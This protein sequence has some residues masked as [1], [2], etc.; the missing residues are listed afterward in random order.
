M[1]KIHKPREQGFTIIELMVATTIFSIVLMVILASFLQI[2]RMFYKGISVSNT[3]ESARSVVEDITSDMKLSQTFIANPPL[4][5]TSG[6]FCVGN[7][8]Y[9]Y[10]LNSKIGSTDVTSPLP[11]VPKGIIKSTVTSCPPPIASA[12]SDVQQLLGPDMQLNDFS[13]SCPTLNNCSL[14]VHIIFYGFDNSVFSST[15]HPA[16]TS[17]DHVAAVNDKDAFCS[18]PLLSTQF[19]AVADINSIIAMRY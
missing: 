15:L 1:K 8:R 16:D 19:C 5:P 4:S 10:G 18:G 7:H 9:V 13:V 17:T 11:S 3:Q 6:Y 14:H 2:G 12:G